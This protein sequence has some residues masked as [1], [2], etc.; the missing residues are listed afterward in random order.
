MSESSPADQTHQNDQDRTQ[1]AVE[2]LVQY[3]QK[4][5]VCTA[6]AALAIGF[7]LGRIY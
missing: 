6:L 2:P 1:E 3:V 7:M 5:P 4:H